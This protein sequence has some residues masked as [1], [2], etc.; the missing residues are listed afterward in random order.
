M[1]REVCLDDAEKL[2]E[3]YAPYVKETAISFEYEVPAVEEFRERIR[4][5]ME[6]YPY[7]VAESQ[8]EILGYCYAGPFHSRKAYEKSVEM[9]IYVQAGQRRRGVGR[10]LY[11][12]LEERLK[13][14]GIRNLYACIAWPEQEDE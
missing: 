1:I 11:L 2:L 7:L 3:I 8:G 13:V 10:S 4:K 14:Q 6:K 5:T 9:S 12:A